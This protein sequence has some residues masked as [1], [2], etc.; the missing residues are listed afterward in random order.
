[1][2]VAVSEAGEAAIWTGAFGLVGIVL[3]GALELIRTHRAHVREV[4]E[5]RNEHERRKAA[6]EESQRLR[7]LA[8]AQLREENTLQHADSR[9]VL[10]RI[11][12]RQ[13]RIETSQTTMASRLERV[14]TKVDR[15]DERVDGLTAWQTDHDTRER[16]A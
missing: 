2:V 13:E 8:I 15:L 4:K 11:D 10:D 6:E 12:Q 7:D 9:S 3:A 5:W 14:D 1:M 16:T